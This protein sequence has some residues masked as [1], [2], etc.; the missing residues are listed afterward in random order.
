[1]NLL[2]CHNNVGE[3]VGRRRKGDLPFLGGRWRKEP[4]VWISTFQRTSV[5]AR[6]NRK[7]RAHPT[8]AFSLG[9]L[10]MSCF[11]LY[12][13]HTPELWLVFLWSTGLCSPMMA[14]TTWGLHLNKRFIERPAP[15]VD[16]LRAG[17]INHKW[18][19]SDT[20]VMVKAGLCGRGRLGRW[21]SKDWKEEAFFY[22]VELFLIIRDYSF[23][24]FQYHKRRSWN[25]YLLYQTGT[26]NYFTSLYFGFSSEKWIPGKNNLTCKN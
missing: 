12:P 1:M 21:G 11:S 2:W 4:W 17:P 15:K 16:V 9:P 3:R 18:S 19:T 22:F 23:K 14:P 10:L 26:W 8:W 25:L 7:V 20:A 24:N 5:H 13:P 6:L